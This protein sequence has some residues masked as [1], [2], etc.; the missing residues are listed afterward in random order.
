MNSNVNRTKNIVLSGLNQIYSSTIEEITTIDQINAMFLKNLLEHSE[1]SD[2]STEKIKNLIYRFNNNYNTSK[3][4]ITKYKLDLETYIRV[5]VKVKEF[6]M[7]ELLRL[8]NYFSIEKNFLQT[9]INQN[10][11][12]LINNANPLFLYY[13]YV[14]LEFF[15][16]SDIIVFKLEQ[17]LKIEISQ[18]PSH[19]IVCSHELEYL[20]EFHKLNCWT[21]YLTSFVYNSRFI[22]KDFD[23]NIITE[24]NKNFIK[25]NGKFFCMATGNIIQIEFYIKELFKFHYSITHLKLHIYPVAVQLH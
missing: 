23:L 14:I 6:N 3:F 19:Y 15:N 8:N 25:K 7:I 22:S 12:I 17:D 5:E 10:I 4:D 20:Y 21:I 9:Y 11:Y 16:I 24:K 18:H 13:E 1:L 2:K